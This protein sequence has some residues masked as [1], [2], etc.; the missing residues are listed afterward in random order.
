MDFGGILKGVWEGLGRPKSLIFAFLSMFFRSN[1]K[2]KK[3][4]P[5]RARDSFWDGPAECAA[6]GERKREG[7]RR[8]KRQDLGRS[9]RHELEEALLAR[10]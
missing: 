4:T 9:S 1:K 2:R 6:S 5:K 7:F 8:L 3:R 10:T